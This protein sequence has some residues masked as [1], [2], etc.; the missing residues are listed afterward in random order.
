MKKFSYLMFLLV[1]I[2]FNA[3]V[4]ANDIKSITMDIFIDENGN[5]QVEEVWKAN[6]TSGTEGYKPYYNLGTSDITNFKVKMNGQAFTSKS[7]WDID[8]S[9]AEK[10]YK[11]GINVIDDGYELCFGI[12]KYGNN[13]YT[14]EYTITNFV[15]RLTDADMV[16]WQLIP[17]DLSDKPEYVYI[18]I[19]SDFAYSDTLD[20]WGYG[21]GDANNEGYAY[22]YDGYIEMTKEGSLASDEYMTVLVK[23][24]K[25]TFNTNSTIDED[26][27][28]YLDMAQSG[29]DVYHESSTS[30]G[31]N[32]ISI[33]VVMFYLLIFII[34]II[35]IKNSSNAYGTKN[36]KFPPKAKKDL[37]NAP[38][39]RD[40]P[41][42]KDIIKAY[43]VACQY[44]L[45]KNKTDFL[46]AILLKWLKFGNIEN[47]QINEKDMA[48]KLI[49]NDNLNEREIELYDMMFKAAKD[50]VLER[51]EFKDWCQDNYNKILKWF[52]SVIDDVTDEYVKEG[53]IKEEKKTFS[54]VYHVSENMREQAMQM[55]G[56]KN[57]LK[58]FSNIENREAI[59]VKIWDEY[60][61]Y[62]QIFGIAKEVAKE[63][64]RLYPD[65]ITEDYYNDIIFIHTI[66]YEGVHA[67]SVAK[68]RAESYSSGGGGFSS[69]GGG[70]GSFGGGG[71]GGGFR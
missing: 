19:H 2:F 11:S 65:V 29:A 1:T 27:D 23:F 70:G 69:S 18:K 33:F 52:N 61:M 12:S 30:N 28:Y 68:S 4:Y 20:V 53:L 48:L 43:W 55:A 64:K 51:D 54:T 63:F 56:L 67:A 36:L 8:A 46:G 60:L 3:K 26:F 14:L 49:K 38:F 40:I 9:F 21:Y 24:P 6:L 35:A 37:K 62:A 59:E 15:S 13:T 66:S 45:V 50:G 34:P 31:S 16:Y 22:V 41:C 5:A 42:N 57:F 44:N 17:Y 10:S 58:E 7:F 32:I 39:F 25:G 71:G 47:A